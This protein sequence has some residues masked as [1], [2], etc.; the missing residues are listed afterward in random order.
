MNKTGIV[1]ENP[2]EGWKLDFTWNPIV[3]CKNSCKD[4]DGKPYCYAERLNNRFKW[5]PDFKKP[6]FY[7]ERL[8]EPAK[9]KKPSTIFV[10]SMGDLFGEW[11]PDEWITEVLTVTMCN[12]GH[13]F[14]FLTKNPK[15]YLEFEFTDNCWLGTTLDHAKNKKRLIDMAWLDWKT[16]TFVSVEPLLSDFSNVDFTGINLVIVGADTSP[17]AKPPKKEWINSI[18]HNNIFYKSNIKRFM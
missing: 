4:A 13:K 6:V 9:L 10:V 14:M 2:K 5:I 7:P 8:I 17:G 3:G 12:P 11:I 18:K 16:K 1:W 15:R